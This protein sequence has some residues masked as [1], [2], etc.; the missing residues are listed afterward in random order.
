VRLFEAKLAKCIYIQ[1][2]KYGQRLLE[3][4]DDSCLGSGVEVYNPGGCTIGKLLFKMPICAVLHMILIQFYLYQKKKLLLEHMLDLC[5]S[6]CI[7][8]W[9]TVVRT[10]LGASFEKPEPYPYMQEILQNL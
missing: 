4:E 1:V 5:Q 8:S 6:H 9:S 2:V 10:V 3:M 7:T